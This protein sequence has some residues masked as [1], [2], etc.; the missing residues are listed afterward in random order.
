MV[1]KLLE[2]AQESWRRL[3]G[4]NHLPKLVRGVKFNDGIEV[5]AKPTDHQRVIAAA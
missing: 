3:D 5:F 1:F 4:H 2:G